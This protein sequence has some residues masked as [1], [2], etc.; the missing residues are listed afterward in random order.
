MTLSASSNSHDDRNWRINRHWVLG[1]M[2]LMTAANMPVFD[3]RPEE[4]DMEK[5]AS[6]QALLADHS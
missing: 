1:M 2:A 6:M 4:S 3:T 5:V